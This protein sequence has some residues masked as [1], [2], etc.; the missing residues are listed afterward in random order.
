MAL[1]VLVKE[2]VCRI[3]H[4]GSDLAF[5]TMPEPAC[6]RG[7][8]VQECIEVAMQMG[9]AVTPIELFPRHAPSVSVSPL[10]V[11]FG[12]ER[13]NLA[14]FTRVIRTGRGVLTGRSRHHCHAVAYHHGA[15]YDPNGYVYAYSF[16]ACESRGLIGSCA[17]RLSFIL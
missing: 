13:G 8:H 5:P 12:D 10:R 7:F 9:F 17:W 3:G 4:D 6:R 14:R 11:L 16:P 2:F 1:D 15:V